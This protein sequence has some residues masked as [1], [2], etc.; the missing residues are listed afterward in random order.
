MDDLIEFPARLAAARVDGRTLIGKPVHRGMVRLGRRSMTWQPG[1]VA[2]LFFVRNA[3]DIREI[4][5]F[6]VIEGFLG[7]AYFFPNAGETPMRGFVARK[8][9]LLPAL[10]A[11]G[12][13]LSRRSTWPGMIAAVPAGR[14]VNWTPEGPRSE[15]GGSEGE[16]PV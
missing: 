15:A 11:M 6:Q 16:S 3:I 8:S 14:R 7:G 2:R 4:D 1:R 12:Y 9:T 13:E 5:H 10:E